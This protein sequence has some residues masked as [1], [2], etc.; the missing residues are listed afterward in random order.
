MTK[1]RQMRRHARRMRRYGLQPM[2]VIND[3]GQLPDLI[4][5]LIGRWL[6]RYRSELVPVY[7]TLAIAVAGWLLHASH[8][9]A[10][11]YVLVLATVV[12]SVLTGLGH[13]V[14]LTR[15]SERLYAAAV[16]M[17]A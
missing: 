17:A 4:V 14:G 2:V 15:R 12:G 16:T 8:P 6:W 13:R 7:L 5:V 11:P 1:P 9:Y 10:W 3:G